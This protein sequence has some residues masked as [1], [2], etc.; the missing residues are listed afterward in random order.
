MPLVLE[1][2]NR[3]HR[4]ERLVQGPE[5]KLDHKVELKLEH[6]VEG[7]E[8]KLEPKVEGLE[9]LE[10]KLEH[11]VEELKLEHKVEGL[12]LK[13]EH[14]VERQDPPDPTALSSPAMACSPTTPWWRCTPLNNP[15]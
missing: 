4:V 9:G 6:K 11:K 1:P 13:L 14:T 8:L 12:V 7:L 5:L 3:E 10:L 15:E 2:V